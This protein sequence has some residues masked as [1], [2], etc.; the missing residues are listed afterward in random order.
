MIL[1]ILVFIIASVIGYKLISDVPKMLHTPLMSGMNALS[2]ITVIG[3]IV[4]TATAFG[5]NSRIMG[6]VAIIMAV[7][8]IMAGF[9]VTHKMLK[10]F[11][12]NKTGDNS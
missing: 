5:L 3:S 6:S 10:K 7:I 8:N 11:K 1:Q 12:D 9:Q 2:G 4:I